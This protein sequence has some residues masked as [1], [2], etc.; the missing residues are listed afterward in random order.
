MIGW[1][2]GNLL[3]VEDESILVEANG[4]GYEVFVPQREAVGLLSKINSEVV[5]HI[6]TYVREDALLLYGFS[7]QW[8]KKFFMQLLKVSGVGPKMALGMLSSA[9]AHDIFS[10][11]LQKN[12]NQLKSL[13]KV[14]Q[15]LAEQLILGLQNSLAKMPAPEGVA[16]LN[17]QIS[18][19][20]ND[21]VS[22]LLNLGFK[23]L[24]IQEAI[25]KVN[26]E[27]SFEEAMKVSL[28]ELRG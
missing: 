15:K 5:F 26:Q 25:Q 6:Y 16:G 8:E 19:V 14:G 9:S 17:E 12:T 23:N 10:W 21:V 20:R 4:V 11:I 18:T 7:S 27:M 13:P 22:A 2:K 24:E 28:R 1:L 3:S